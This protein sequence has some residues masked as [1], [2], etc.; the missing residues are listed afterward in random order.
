[1]QSRRAAGAAPWRIVRRV[2]RV[3]RAFVKRVGSIAKRRAR[4]DAARATARKGSVD[5]RSGVTWS[6]RPGPGRRSR[7]DCS[8]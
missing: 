4:G 7:W 1:M 8:A 2:I 6:R 3:N 5:Q